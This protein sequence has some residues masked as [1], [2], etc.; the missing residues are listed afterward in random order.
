MAEPSLA[1]VAGAEPPGTDGAFVAAPEGG[2][3][4][5]PVLGGRYLEAELLDAL[6]SKAYCIGQA[7]LDH[8]DGQVLLDGSHR[9]GTQ[10]GHFLSKCGVA[11]PAASSPRPG[12]SGKGAVTDG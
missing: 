6:G 1:R 3:G 9:D 8:E 7:R 5:Y 10:G 11:A 4:C 12:W 2:V